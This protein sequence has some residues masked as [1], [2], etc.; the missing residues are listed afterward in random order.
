[1]SCYIV[2][3]TSMLYHRRFIHAGYIRTRCRLW[4]CNFHGVSSLST[5]TFGPSLSVCIFTVSCSCHLLVNV[6]SGSPCGM[7][8]LAHPLL[9]LNLDHLSR[10]DNYVIDAGNRGWMWDHWWGEGLQPPLQFVLKFR[11]GRKFV[12]ADTSR[13]IVC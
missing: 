2:T 8:K 12:V 3:T 1:M 10:M 6:E 7:C 13:R 5:L 9:T 11:V 4:R